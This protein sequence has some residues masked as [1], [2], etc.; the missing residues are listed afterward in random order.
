MAI[1]M[2]R[3]YPGM[4]ARLS[5]GATTT[6]V[7]VLL[8]A[9]TGKERYLVLAVHG[10]FGPDVV[11]P[12]AAVWHVDDRV[13]VALTMR[14]AAALPHFDPAAYGPAAG[15]CSRRHL[16]AGAWSHRSA[17]RRVPRVLAEKRQASTGRIGSEMPSS[18]VGPMGMPHL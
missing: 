11:A 5:D 15:L 9:R 8:D 6:V 17:T 12:Y 18:A 3:V 4:T 14:E 2:K 7:D 1:T 10:F 16:M 13:H